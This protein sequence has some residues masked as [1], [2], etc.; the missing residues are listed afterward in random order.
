MCP[1][2]DLGFDMASPQI[3]ADITV[4]GR[5]IKAIDQPGKQ[6]FLYVFDR[7]TGEP[8]WPV[9]DP[10]GRPAI[11]PRAAGNNKNPCCGDM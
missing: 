8:V 9:D 4:N 10:A 2:P 6:A 1:P 3:L 7:V 5:A 11:V